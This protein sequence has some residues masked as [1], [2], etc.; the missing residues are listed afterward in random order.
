MISITSRGVTGNNA[1]SESIPRNELL[2][3]DALQFGM[4]PANMTIELSEHISNDLF[5]FH[6]VGKGLGL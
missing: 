3:L 4:V 5:E 6:S 2:V 1:A